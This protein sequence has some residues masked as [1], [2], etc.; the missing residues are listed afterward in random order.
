MSRVHYFMLIVDLI[1]FIC[2]L[3]KL[4]RIG[5]IIAR[6]ISDLFYFVLL[7]LPSI[8]DLIR[9]VVLIDLGLI[10]DVMQLAGLIVMILSD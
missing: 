5:I 10:N 6:Y 2:S 4:L 7:I 1:F 8:L 9:T 3:S